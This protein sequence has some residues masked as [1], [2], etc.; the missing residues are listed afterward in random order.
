M[1]GIAGI[2][3]RD[4][5]FRVSGEILQRM[6][7][8]IYHRGP[9]ETG[10]W[11][12]DNV[13]IAMRRL[14][15]IDL[16]GG[17][18]PIFN[19]DRTMCVVFNGEIYNHRDVRAALEK[20]G[21]RYA[22][23]SD[24]E[25]ILHAYEEYG[26]DCVQHLRGMFAFAIW[27]GK[28]EKLFLARDRL[29]I[30]P[31]HYYFDGSRF[32]F[33][34]EIKSILEC[35][36]PREIHKPSLVT[37]MAYGY[38][39]DPLTMFE[40]IFK[41]PPG[42]VL[43]LKKGTLKV[44]RYWDITFEVGKVYPEE[45]YIE[46]IIEILSEAVKIRL[47]SE[48]PLGAFLSGGI[49]SSVVVAL[50][51]KNMA[52]PV[53]TFSIGFDHERFTEFRYAR[54]VAERYGTDHHEEIVTP[55]AEGI[56]PDLVRQFDEPFADSSMIPTYY[57]SKIAKKRVTV[58]LS[59]DG[60]DELFGGYDRYRTSRLGRYAD[61]F[62]LGA[63]K[64]VLGRLGSLFPEW[65]PAVHTVRYLSCSDDERY[66]SMLSKGLSDIHRKVFHP[67]LLGEI[68]TSDPSP[69]MIEHLASVRGKDSLTRRQYLDV[70]T[71]LPGDILTKV[72]RTSM[73]VS[74]E[75]RVPILDHH[76]VEFAA[77]IPPEMKVRGMDTKYLFK[78]VAE[79]LVPKAAVYR[80]KMGFSIPAGAWIRREWSEM[81][82]DLVLG[83]RAMERS[84]FEP[85]FLRNLMAEH[86]WG[87]RD[88][89]YL[90]WTLMILEMWHR[91]RIDTA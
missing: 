15:I 79:R 8:V 55:D 75:A 19:E 39:P 82:H 21:H 59:G 34:S 14:S 51:A 84:Y 18:Q 71:Y 88:N 4:D 26:E 28:E 60:G 63:R 76:L 52:E 33:G 10:M 29:G 67:G 31:L 83:K 12:R 36:V 45:H 17:S 16:S 24:T 25:S 66:L 57:V 54:M 72:D 91:E 40:K 9:D 58:A 90:I 6:C 38:V 86:R 23:N 7:D 56:L 53:K 1:C 68:G 80:P 20:R 49:D 2:H 89:S 46:R 30:K 78:K 65:F 27:D 41:L 13:G 61:R 77:T 73:L 50:M 11:H 42:H 47:M 64:R 62:P 85:S 87:R 74:L 81:S 35:D 5:R 32:I 69:V 44:R 22:T 43:T 3:S 48:V 70:K 37:Y